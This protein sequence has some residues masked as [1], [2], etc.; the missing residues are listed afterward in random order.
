MLTSPVFQHNQVCFRMLNYCIMLKEEFIEPGCAAHHTTCRAVEN[1]PAC[2]CSAATSD[3]R[4]TL[5]TPRAIPA[6][7]TEGRNMQLQ[8]N[9]R[10]EPVHTGKS[11]TVRCCDSSRRCRRQRSAETG[12]HRW[13][14]N[15]SAL[16]RK[17]DYKLAKVA[18]C[19][20]DHDMTTLEHSTGFHPRVAKTQK[21]T[22]NTPLHQLG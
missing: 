6:H 4:C 19:Q 3:P 16:H 5:H 20:A 7:T 12:V 18:Q 15:I 1:C 2:K 10:E 14:N 13:C 21:G 8:L 17:N 22:V 9:R 11:H